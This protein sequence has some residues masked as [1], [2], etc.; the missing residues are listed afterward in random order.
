MN[1][2]DRGDRIVVVDDSYG[3]ETDGFV[4][5]EGYVK[6]E[7]VGLLTGRRQYAVVLDGRSSDD[8]EMFYPE[9]IELAGEQ[10][11]AA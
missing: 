1:T 5:R 2:F 9:Q 7:S 6:R 3:P 4:G 11:V 8:D 10:R